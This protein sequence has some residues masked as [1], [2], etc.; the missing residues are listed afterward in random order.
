MLH[1]LTSEKLVNISYLTLKGSLMQLF[2]GLLFTITLLLSAESMSQNISEKMIV[3]SSKFNHIIEED[4]LKLKV[5]FIENSATRLL[6]EK[7]NLEIGTET[8][9]EY[10]IIILKPIRSVELRNELLVVLSP[11]F[12]DI[13]YI[14]YHVNEPIL[15]D[16]AIVNPEEIKE[17]VPM[18]ITKSETEKSFLE[19]EVGL[20]WVSIWILSMLGLVMSISS[21]KKL[22]AFDQIQIKFKRKQAKIETEINNL[23][24]L[25][26]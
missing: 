13:F 18:K 21:R 17:K 16:K 15:I 1:Y 8:L 26:E 5:H 3:S 19:D 22:I 7:Y 6:Q 12:K 20:Q 23:G 14:E 24:A 11:L 10:Q 25:D 4:L 2:I 9:G